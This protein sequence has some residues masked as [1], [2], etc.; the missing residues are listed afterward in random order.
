M[1]KGSEDKYI[2]DADILAI[3]DAVNDPL[4]QKDVASPELKPEIKLKAIDLK[5]IN[6]SIE[7]I[8]FINKEIQ[9]LSKNDASFNICSPVMHRSAAVCVGYEPLVKKLDNFATAC[10]IEHLK[11]EK[12]KRIEVLTMTYGYEYSDYV[13]TRPNPEPTEIL[14]TQHHNIIVPA[15]GGDLGWSALSSSIDNK[16]T[17]DSDVL[18]D[19]MRS[20]M[21]DSE[22]GKWVASKPW[23]VPD[24]VPF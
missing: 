1:K 11:A 20:L 17:I 13:D 3:L 4:L 23:D 24:D 14:P 10:V 15:D 8:A 18:K 2:G 6:Q 12:Q 5:K 9:K 22:F 19:A 7:D 16:L 21:E